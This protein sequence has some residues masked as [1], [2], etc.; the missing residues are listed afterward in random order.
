METQ[1]NHQ[2]VI[3]DSVLIWQ[4]GG[5]IFALASSIDVFFIHFFKYYDLITLIIGILMVLLSA[6]LTIIADRPRRILRLEYRYLLFHNAKEIPFDEIESIHTQKDSGGSHSSTTYRI[7]ATLKNGQNV[8]FRSISSS[9][10]EIP[11][12]AARLQAFINHKSPSPRSKVAQ[13]A[14]GSDHPDDTND[15]KESSSS[16]INA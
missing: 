6:N 16:E 12:Q 5:L 14:A 8:P 15:D 13:P 1:G 9:G 7:I 4:I 11:R 10:S 3:H 2:L